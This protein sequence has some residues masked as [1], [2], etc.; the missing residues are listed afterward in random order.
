MRDQ[1]NVAKLDAQKLT[2]EAPKANFP[3]ANFVASLKNVLHENGLGRDWDWDEYSQQFT[4]S[5]HE[6]AALFGP[7]GS[8]MAGVK[9]R[10]S[11][12][13][14]VQLDPALPLSEEIARLMKQRD[15]FI[16]LTSG[17][18]GRFEREQH[19]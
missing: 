7:E 2:V 8:K 12:T 14:H 9:F 3:W 6:G 13:I 10:G 4:S 16:A 11:F 19:A 18:V 5:W 15:A 1:K 17:S